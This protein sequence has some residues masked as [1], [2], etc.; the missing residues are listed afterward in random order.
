MY[1]VIP[2]FWAL[3][4]FVNFNNVDTF[5]KIILVSQLEIKDSNPIY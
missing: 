2:L 3:Q 1:Q 4:I 5:E